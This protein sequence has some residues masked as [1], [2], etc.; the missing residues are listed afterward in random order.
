VRRC[1]SPNVRTTSGEL[2]MQTQSR[3]SWLAGRLGPCPCVGACPHPI[4]G[5]RALWPRSAR[6]FIKKNSSALWECGS[7]APRRPALRG[8]CL[9]SKPP[10]KR[11]QKLPFPPA[12]FFCFSNN[13]RPGV[14]RREAGATRGEPGR[15]CHG[16][17]NNWLVA[18]SR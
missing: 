3:D 4:R 5:P 6:L 7:G 15:K 14:E 18:G 17:S 12:A 16:V 2:V 9:R 10:G 11:K 13:I 8:P 1:T